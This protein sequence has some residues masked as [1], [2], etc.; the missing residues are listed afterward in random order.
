MGDPSEPEPDLIRRYHVFLASPG[1]MNGERQA[2]RE[3]FAEFNRN[4]AA[5]WG[6]EF[7]VIDWENY[8]LAG[9]GRPQ[10]LITAQMLYKTSSTPAKFK[11]VLR[12][13]L[14]QWLSAPQRPWIEDRAAPTPPPAAGHRTASRPP[15]R[16]ILLLMDN[17]RGRGMRDGA[18]SARAR[19]GFPASY[20]SPLTS[21]FPDIAQGNVGVDSLVFGA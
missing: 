16:P 4:I 6:V 7:V 2:V 19:W 9:V 12:N 1:D 13:D 11:D 3:I 20:F 17:A 18:G 10:E 14:E 15:R 5:G 8:G 21:H